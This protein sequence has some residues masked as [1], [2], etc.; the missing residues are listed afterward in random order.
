MPLVMDLWCNGISISCFRLVFTLV[1]LQFLRDQTNLEDWKL[2]RVE[3]W[4]TESAI[5]RWSFDERSE[6]ERRRMRKR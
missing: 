4:K 3:W 1:F 5:D 2:G 6:R